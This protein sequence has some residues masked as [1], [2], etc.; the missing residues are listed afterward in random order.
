[1]RR[2]ALRGHAARG[3]NMELNGFYSDF[4]ISSSRLRAFRNAVR[5]QPLPQVM[6]DGMDAAAFDPMALPPISS[7]AALAAL[8]GRAQP[9]VRAEYATKAASA[10][11]PSA[12]SHETTSKKKQKSKDR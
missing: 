6:A 12:P 8:A 4:A 11:A 7:N 9:Y 1:M 3:W 5:P 2:D 10:P